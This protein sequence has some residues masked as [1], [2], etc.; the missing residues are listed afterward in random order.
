MNGEVVDRRLAAPR[1]WAISAIPGRS[2]LGSS[3]LFEVPLVPADQH[4][5][6]FGGWMLSPPKLQR[7]AASGTVFGPW[8]PRL[9]GMS[10][11]DVYSPQ[12]NSPHQ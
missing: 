7:K 6:A 3:A 1:F 5:H 8:I 9:A 2:G 11:N 12:H 10:G 4:T